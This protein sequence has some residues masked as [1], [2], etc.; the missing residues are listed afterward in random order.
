MIKTDNTFDLM[1]LNSIW[2]GQKIKHK[3][4]CAIL[5]DRQKCSGDKVKQMTETEN[6]RD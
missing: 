2:G 3:Q 1:E 4:L 6:R 5:S